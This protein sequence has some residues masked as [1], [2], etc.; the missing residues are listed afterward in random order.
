MKTSKKTTII[1]I[2]LSLA[3]I[4]SMGCQTGG[5]TG[6][7]MGSVAGAGVGNLIG[8][9]TESTLIGA[10]VGGGIGYLVGNES[11]KQQA[12]AHR[13]ALHHEIN[14]TLVNVRNSNGSTVQVR[15][16]RCGVGWKGPRGE[17]YDQLP[18]NEQL[19]PVYGF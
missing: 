14:S 4:F 11:D 8:H 1:A 6:A 19:R 15:L 9:D 2:A 5:Q 12:S 16:A 3:I 10:A 7:L 17:Y 18:T 13:E